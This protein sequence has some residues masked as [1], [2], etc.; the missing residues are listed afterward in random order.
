MQ[1]Y[2]LFK[3]YIGITLKT[4]NLFQLIRGITYLLRLD[5]YLIGSILFVTSLGPSSLRQAQYKLE[6]RFMLE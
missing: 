6:G 3:V 1:K 5:F 4:L 2:K